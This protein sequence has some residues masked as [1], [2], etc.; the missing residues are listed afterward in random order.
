[1][2]DCRTLRKYGLAAEHSPEP[3]SHPILH[4][5]TTQHHLRPHK[6]MEHDP[7]LCMALDSAPRPWTEAG[8][9]APPDQFLHHMR[10]LLDR[11]GYDVVQQ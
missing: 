7:Q 11:C 3:C 1:M 4:L 8:P 5:P 6:Q 10:P 2:N 9:A